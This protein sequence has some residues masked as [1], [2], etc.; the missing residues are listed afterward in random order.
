V[1]DILISNDAQVGERVRRL[2]GIVVSHPL[3]VGAIRGAL[4]RSADR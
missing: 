3:D 4:R 1:T 2:D